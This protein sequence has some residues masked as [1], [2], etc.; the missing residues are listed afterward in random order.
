[1]IDKSRMK[2]HIWVFVNCLIPNATFSTKTHDLMN[3]GARNFSTRCHPSKT[4]MNNVAECGIVESVLSWAKT[5][6][7]ND[8]AKLSE[9]NKK[10]RL[11]G[12]PKLEDAN[13]AG[14]ENSLKCT[15]ILTAGDSVK[16]LAVSGLGTVGRDTFGVFPLNND[17]LKICNATPRQIRSNGKINKLVHAIG[18]E[19]NKK[20]STTDDLKTLRYAK[21]MIMTNQN[22]YG[23][24]LKG[25]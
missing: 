5:K 2:Q 23:S 6:V 7:E 12:V 19:Y 16:S 10:K 11:L 1:M 18:S 21:I 9:K 13:D 15:L 8:L 14:T 20:Y 22:Q 25:M 3:L 24:R 4:F 17:L